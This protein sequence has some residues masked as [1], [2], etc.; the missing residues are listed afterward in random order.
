MGV[1]RAVVA[2]ASAGATACAGAGAVPMPPVPE[3]MPVPVPRL[4]HSA[5]THASP[6]SLAKAPRSAAVLSHA[7]LD[8]YAPD[9][10]P[11][12]AVLI[13]SKAVRWPK[14]RV[15]RLPALAPAEGAVVLRHRTAF[16]VTSGSAELL[17]V[18]AGAGAVRGTPSA[19]HGAWEGLTRDVRP[20]AVKRWAPRG[21]RG[22]TRE[23][24]PHGAV[25]VGDGMS[26]A[27]STPEMALPPPPPVPGPRGRRV[28]PA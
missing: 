4:T 19:L 3:L 27:R 10:G 8:A 1:A 22:C 25:A 6:P 2:G 17:R 28:A 13:L 16:G 23:I 5:W 24:G 18:Y 9:P 14:Y 20:A 11:N 7:M 21:Q 15:E 26:T 12:G